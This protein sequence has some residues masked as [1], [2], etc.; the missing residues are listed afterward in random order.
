MHNESTLTYRSH[1]ITRFEHPATRHVSGF[2]SR[3]EKKIVTRH[4]TTRSE[5]T[6]SRARRDRCFQSAKEGRSSR[7]TRSLDPSRP[8]RR[9]R[10]RRPTSRGRSRDRAAA[11][12]E[13]T[14]RVRFASL[15]HQEVTTTTSCR[16]SSRR[17]RWLHESA[18]SSAPVIERWQRVCHA[19]LGEEWLPSLL[20]RAPPCVETR[21]L[22]RAPPS[23]KT[24][25]AA[26]E[27]ARA[28]TQP[29]ARGTF[30]VKAR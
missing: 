7:A 2:E 25:S 23:V 22:S 21:S 12:V 1:G 19:A 13:M 29:N 24:R 5:Q 11:P 14:R 3:S 26:S 9:T 20:L 30:P 4:G 17:T 8:R 6:A 18:M 28:N 27:A 16:G 15:N 10:S